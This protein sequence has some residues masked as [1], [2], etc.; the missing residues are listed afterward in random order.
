MGLV[1]SLPAPFEAERHRRELRE[2]EREDAVKFVERVLNAAG[3]DAGSSSDA[4]SE[5]IEQLVEAVHCHA[6]TLVLLAPALGKRGVEA[7]RESL[8]ELMADMEKRFPGSREKSV[9]ASVELSL[10]R[11]S[12]ANRDRARVLAVF[13]GGVNPGVLHLMMQWDMNDIGALAGEL[14]QTGLADTSWG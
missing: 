2:M 12:G 14:I 13:H 4:A 9:F 10:R 8:V 1:T 7:T 6:R 11:M 5:E 3:Q